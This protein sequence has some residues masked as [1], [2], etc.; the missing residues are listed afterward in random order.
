MQVRQHRFESAVSP[1]TPYIAAAARAQSDMELLGP[2]EGA[3]PGTCRALL[4]SAVEGDAE[5]EARQKAEFLLGLP[6]IWVPDAE[7][8]ASKQCADGATTY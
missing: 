8:Q 6:N 4:Q 2:E 5:R 7:K 3:P 1:Q